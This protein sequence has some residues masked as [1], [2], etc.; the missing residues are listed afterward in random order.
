MMQGYMSVS[1]LQANN[2]MIMHMS[3]K[4][5]SSVSSR[6]DSNMF[7]SALNLLN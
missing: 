1:E 6:P 7:S 4:E 2:Q 3:R 5:F